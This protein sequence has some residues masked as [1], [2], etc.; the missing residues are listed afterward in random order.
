MFAP[1]L[2]W[3]GEKKYFLENFLDF[4]KFRKIFLIIDF[5]QIDRITFFGLC[6]LP[7]KIFLEST[8]F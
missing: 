1:N 2:S 7:K 3:I 8:K 6:E 5:A 4:Q